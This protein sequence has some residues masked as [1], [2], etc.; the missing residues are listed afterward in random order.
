MAVCQARV[1]VVACGYDCERIEHG[2]DAM[3]ARRTAPAPHLKSIRQSPS[4]YP[5]RCWSRTRSSHRRPVANCCKPM[6]SLFTDGTASPRARELNC[7]TRHACSFYRCWRQKALPILTIHR[8]SSTPKQKWQASGPSRQ[9]DGTHSLSHQ[10]RFAA[11]CPGVAGTP[12]SVAYA[13]P[14][15]GGADSGAS[16]ANPTSPC[17]GR[18]QLCY[19][20][21]APGAPRPESVSRHAAARAARSG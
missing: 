14:A 19:C 16:R 5:P 12:P 11:D 3:S 2:N 10:R 21:V 8:R 7:W 20:P 9:R 6:S 13:L 17:R 15:R 4:R 1:A 18:S